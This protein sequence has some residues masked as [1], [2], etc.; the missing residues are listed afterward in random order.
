MT[1]HNSFKMNFAVHYSIGKNSLPAPAHPWS[2]IVRSTRKEG[3]FFKLFGSTG[4]L[5]GN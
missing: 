2:I 5:M 4:N 1:N 3:N